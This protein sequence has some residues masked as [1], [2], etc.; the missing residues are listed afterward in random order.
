MNRILLAAASFFGAKDASSDEVV[1]YGLDVS[2]AHTTP[3]ITTNFPWLPHNEDPDNN[4][5]PDEHVDKPVQVLGDRKKVYDDYIQGCRDYWNKEYGSEQG[6]M[7]CDGF[8][9]DRFV[10]SLTQPRSMV[11]S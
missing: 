9:K 8:E 11:V 2:F 3:D 4:P 10:Q 7:A 1:S 6:A 5:M